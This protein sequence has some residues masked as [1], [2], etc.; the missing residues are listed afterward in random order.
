MDI[1]FAHMVYSLINWHPSFLLLMPGSR[2]P[3]RKVSHCRLHLL[4]KQ[5]HRQAET[6]TAEK[7]AARA[8]SCF[9]LGIFKSPPS[10]PSNQTYP[11]FS[12]SVYAGGKTCDRS[13]RL[14][15]RAR[16]LDR[17]CAVYQDILRVLNQELSVIWQGLR[18][19]H[20]SRSTS[21]AASA[22][23]IIIYLDMN[24]NE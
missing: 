1:P 13:A 14:C 16:T 8:T 18:I 12:A 7:G 3:L 9:S 24:I 20:E 4:A 22:D 17:L 6:P 2:C 11:F 19:F 21:P 10:F 5:I 15:R 23:S